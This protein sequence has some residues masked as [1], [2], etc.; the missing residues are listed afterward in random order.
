MDP[1]PKNP[2]ESCRH[3]VARALRSH[4]ISCVVCL[5]RAQG[6]EVVGIDV[7]GNDYL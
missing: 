4:K 7:R 3:H 1:G 2:C 5:L 6:G